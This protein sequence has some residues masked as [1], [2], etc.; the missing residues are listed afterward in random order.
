MGKEMEWVEQGRPEIL[1]VEVL[2]N[3]FLVLRKLPLWVRQEM[4]F[5]R[6]V[7]GVVGCVGVALSMS[8]GRSPLCEC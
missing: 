1:V 5:L 3:S 8:E 6:V 4:P 7:V 2:P